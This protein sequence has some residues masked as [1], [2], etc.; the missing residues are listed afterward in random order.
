MTL[1]AVTANRLDDGVVVYLTEAAG[2]S[3]NLN[4]AARAE[5]GP[6]ADE[7]LAKGGADFLAVVG[8]Y[9]IDVVSAEN[10]LQL[11]NMRET[12][13]AAGPSVRTDLGKQAGN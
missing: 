7:L 13:R 12:I 9:L 8:P 11:V 2:W 3:E 4:D 5:K 10:G 6:A 1:S